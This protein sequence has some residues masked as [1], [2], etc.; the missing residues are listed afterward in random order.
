MRYE[1]N[2]IIARSGWFT[3]G[4]LTLLALVLWRTAGFVY[5]APLALLALMVAFKFRDPDR[6]VPASRLGV[7]APVDGK[8]LSIRR[9]EDGPFGTAA[10]KV[11]LRVSP[12]TVYGVRC[13]VEGTVSDP[14]TFC[15][16]SGTLR[17]F[18]LRTDEG[19]AMLLRMEHHG[20]G[21]PKAKVNIGQR[22]GHGE[23]CGS[24]RFAH[25]VEMFLPPTAVARVV[26]HD[27]TE[28]GVTVLAEF[29]PR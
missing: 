28:A 11:R 26:P 22:L 2:P 5:A 8:V 4:M 25:T 13:P 14:A 23:R 9:V 27:R 18:C 24:V 1:T 3:L 15:A 12:F 29:A 6:P 10:L 19:D 17:G 16:A 20:F 7:V 21:A